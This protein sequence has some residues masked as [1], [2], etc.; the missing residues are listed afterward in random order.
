MQFVVLHVNKNVT[1]NKPKRYDNMNYLDRNEFNYAPSREVVEA[2]KDFDINKLCF[3]TRIYDEGKKSIF[4]V[5]LSDLYQI[6]EKQILLGYGGEDILKQFVHYFL[7]EADGNKTMLIPKF[8]WWY[9]KS[10]ADE[11]DGVSLQYPLYEDGDT[12]RYDFRALKD[13]LVAEKPKLLLLASPNNPTGNSLTPNEMD[14]LLSYVP[15]TTYVIVD[16]AYA[17]FVMEDNSYIKKLIEKYP[18]LLISR[19]LSK[20]YG[21]PGLRMGFAFMGKSF[22]KFGRYSNKYLGYNRFSEDIAIAALKSEK[23]YRNIA[24]LMNEDRK[25]YEKEVGTLPGFKVY[26]SAANFI[27][28][29]Y[30]I[31]LKESL[32]K[33][34]AS[35]DYKVKFMDEPDINTHLRIT[36]GRPEQNRVVADTI[37]KVACR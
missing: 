33:A 19:T 14:E 28:I 29:K 16:E 31:E 30:P 13:M 34:F 7:T 36:L 2:L 5:F 17:S 26:K 23:H 24:H 32:K 20:F 6:D 11:V 3:Y 27:L 35:E 4:S 8:S 22:E 10:I 25:M 15:Q 9:Y 21:L 12:Y 1:K 18:N 37:L